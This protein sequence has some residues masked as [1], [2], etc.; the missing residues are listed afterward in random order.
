MRTVLGRSIVIV[1]AAG[2]LAAVYVTRS[3]VLLRVTH[4]RALEAVAP[5]HSPAHPVAPPTVTNEHPPASRGTATKPVEPP[6]ERRPSAAI[7]P[8]DGRQRDASARLAD[9]FLF[10]LVALGNHRANGAR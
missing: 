10:F 4:G 5:A 6:P 8:D 3:D 9:S 1:A 2:L 7:H